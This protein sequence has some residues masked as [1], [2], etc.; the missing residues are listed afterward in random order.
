MDVYTVIA[1]MGLLADGPAFFDEPGRSLYSSSSHDSGSTYPMHV[2]WKMHYSPREW[3][4]TPSASDVPAR[5]HVWML[6]HGQRNLSNGGYC[7]TERP[8]D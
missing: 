1:F 8:R 4:R 6:W 2:H 7:T 5:D 3:S